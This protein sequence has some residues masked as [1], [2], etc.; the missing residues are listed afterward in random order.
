MD[1]LIADDA[2]LLDEAYDEWEYMGFGDAWGDSGT[3][4]GEA[5]VG[6]QCDET[7]P[8]GSGDVGSDTVGREWGDA[9]AAAEAARGEDGG[10]GGRAGPGWRRRVTTMARW[11]PSAWAH[12]CGALGKRSHD[13]MRGETEDVVGD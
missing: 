12:M 13:V 7:D 4:E 2:A 9:A 10:G 11:E 5:P 8:A 3:R 6:M 1:A